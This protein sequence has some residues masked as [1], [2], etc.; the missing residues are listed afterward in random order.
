M[1]TKRW[2]IVTGSC[3]YRKRE[4]AVSRAPGRDE[5]GVLCPVINLELCR[6]SEGARYLALD[7]W[8]SEEGR[9]GT[10]ALVIF[11]RDF[12]K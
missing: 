4:F 12:K 11:H 8:G 6:S 9:R 3:N 1:K 5:W 10:W 7:W 2:A